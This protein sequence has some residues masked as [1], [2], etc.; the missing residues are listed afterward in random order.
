MGSGAVTL[1]AGLLYPESCE[2]NG[3]SVAALEGSCV[4][5]EGEK[6]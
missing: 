5:R 4:V 6:I 1:W 2:K 3:V